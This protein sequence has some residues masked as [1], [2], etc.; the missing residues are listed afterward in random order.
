MGA[1]RKQN[2]IVVSVTYLDELRCRRCKQQKPQDNF[3]ELRCYVP[4]R[5]R[6]IVRMLHP[7]CKECRTDKKAKWVGSPYYNG[8][9][10][11]YLRRL[12]SRQKGQASTRGIAF[13]VEVEDVINM[14]VAQKGRCA[15]SGKEMMVEE[16][17]AGAKNWFA[18]SIDRIDST[19]NYELDNVQLVCAGVNLMKSTMSQKTF[20]DFCRAVVANQ[21]DVQDELEQLCC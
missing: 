14:F 18:A 6:R 8:K 11:E 2:F 1:R 4:M 17:V 10:D 20:V 3:K 15:L 16:G 21:A 13:L 7:H 19:R 5:G 9:V 12:V